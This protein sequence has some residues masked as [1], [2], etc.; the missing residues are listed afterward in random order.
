MNTSYYE[1]GYGFE[2]QGPVESET[3][4]KLR[5]TV[6]DADSEVAEE[7]N[8]TTHLLRVL[9]VI[10]LCAAG[11][12][13]TLVFGYFGERLITRFA[14]DFFSLM[15]P[16]LNR[17]M[18]FVVTIPIVA[19]TVI[20][21]AS[22]G[23]VGRMYCL[24]CVTVSQKQRALN[25]TINPFATERDTDPQDLATETAKPFN[26][27]A[28]RTSVIKL[29]K[30][31]S[32]ATVQIYGHQFRIK[33][34]P[35]LHKVLLCLAIFFI[36]L[37]A[38]GFGAYFFTISSLESILVD[39][40]EAEAEGSSERFEEL[41]EL[42]S[43]TQFAIFN[44]CCAAQGYSV[45]GSVPACVDGEVDIDSC[46]L[47]SELT[48]FQ[49]E[50]CTC[51]TNSEE[52]FNEVMQQVAERD[53][54][55]ELAG[56]VIEIDPEEVIPGTQIELSAIYPNLEVPLVGYHGEISQA[57]GGIQDGELG[58]GCGTG[59]AR[60]FQLTLF[61]FLQQSST[62]YALV[63]FVLSCV[64]LIC[65]LG[66]LSQV[67]CTSNSFDTDSENSHIVLYPT[68]KLTMN[69]FKPIR[70]MSKFAKV[71]KRTTVSKKD[72]NSEQNFGVANLN[73]LSF[74]D[75]FTTSNRSRGLRKKLLWNRGHQKPRTHMSVIST[76]DSTLSTAV[77]NLLD[78]SKEKSSAAQSHQAEKANQKKLSEQLFNEI[79]V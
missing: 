43:N 13:G 75:A 14:V 15:S 69:S 32:Q 67:I 26:A 11:I 48:F 47:P 71:S 70:V 27:Q 33:K 12:I 29:L 38:V 57:P 60:G 61:E 74:D 77:D 19:N 35:R 9:V 24:L 66:I 52:E 31:Q 4:R 44:T 20:L 42:I 55:N 79:S 65:M 59:F 21:L 18:V 22:I 7:V 28:A 62:T 41:Q 63:G 2:K 58:Y 25:G 45:S 68:K 40:L 50:L 34:R 56:A 23:L 1:A 46:V 73:M 17:V 78:C 16:K 49:E 53:M 72:S 5:K 3:E 36:S 8:A 6:P 39:S 51:H 30:H 54:C 64:Q 37:N 10:S 76:H